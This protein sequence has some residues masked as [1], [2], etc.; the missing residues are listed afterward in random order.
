MYK[1]W[2]EGKKIPKSKMVYNDEWVIPKELEPFM[3]PDCILNN[4][5][6]G[7]DVV[8]TMDGIGYSLFNHKYEEN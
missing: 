4:L 1:N 3:P 8:Y 6:K 5:R 7:I 2:P